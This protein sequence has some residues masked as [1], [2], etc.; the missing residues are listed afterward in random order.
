MSLY[1]AFGPGQTPA[2]VCVNGWFTAP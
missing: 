2:R 1:P